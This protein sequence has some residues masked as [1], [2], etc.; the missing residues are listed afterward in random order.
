MYVCMYVC[1]EHYSFGTCINASGLPLVT[2]FND[3][4]H[5]ITTT[6]TSVNRDMLYFTSKEFYTLLVFVF[7]GKEVSSIFNGIFIT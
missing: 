3:F 4:K 2:N 5:Q 7:V 6:I 1:M